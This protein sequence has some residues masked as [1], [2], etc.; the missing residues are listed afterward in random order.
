MATE[1]LLEVK[2]ENGIK[3]FKSLFFPQIEMRGHQIWWQEQVGQP[4]W[5]LFT[6]QRQR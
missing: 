5:T 1:R 6:G 3:I 4:E 2:K